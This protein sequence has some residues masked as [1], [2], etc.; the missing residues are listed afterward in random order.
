MSAQ[1]ESAMTKAIRA[2]ADVVKA[3][4][5]HGAELSLDQVQGSFGILSQSVIANSQAAVIAHGVAKAARGFT[6]ADL[7]TVQASPALFPLQPVQMPVHQPTPPAASPAGSR[8]TPRPGV[9]VGADGLVE[10]RLATKVGEEAPILGTA[11][12]ETVPDADF[13]EA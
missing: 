2:I 3:V 11:K 4:E 12:T 6:L 10:G 9:L 7:A 8:A 5:K 13:I 1:F